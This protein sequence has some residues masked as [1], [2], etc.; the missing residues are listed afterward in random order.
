[1]SDAGGDD[2]YSLDLSAN[3]SVSR[4]VSDACAQP[5]VPAPAVAIAPP[6]TAAGQGYG[7]TGALGLVEDAAGN[8][9][10]RVRLHQ[11]AT[12]VARDDRTQPGAEVL[13]GHAGVSGPTYRGQGAAIGAGAGSTIDSQGNDKYETVITASTEVR[14]HAAI[15]ANEPSVSVSGGRA[16]A[17]VQGAAGT[18]GSAGGLIDLGG[19][20]VYS[21]SVSSS[22]ARNEAEP[23]AG[24]VMVDAQAAVEDGGNAVGV[25][26]DLD[27]VQDDMYSTTPA[28]PACT[29]VRGQAVWQ[30][31]GRVG[32]GVNA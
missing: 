26:V 9:T 15:A 12:A 23:V 7:A 31:C 3:S 22:M 11:S 20:D 13:S 25:A 8:D 4:S 30:D 28:T 6:I 16:K 5:C 18:T 27:G 14:G 2:T 1:L 19:Y 17:L 24:A 29:G 32:I 21:A 10:Y